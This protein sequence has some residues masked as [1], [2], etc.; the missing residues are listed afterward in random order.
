[1]STRKQRREIDK[2]IDHL[3]TYLGKK[4][5]WAKRFDEFLSQIM[6]PVADMSDMDVDDV[7]QYLLDGPYGNMAWGYLF[8]ELATS[9][10]DDEHHSMVDEYLKQRG[11]R[12]GPAGR[13]YLKALNSSDVKLWEVCNIKVGAHVDVRKFGS[14]DK[15]VRVK[16]VSASE[17]LQQW[18]CLAARVLN[19]DNSHMF[20][21]G[22]LLF[23]P[24][25]AASVQQVLDQVASE[26]SEFI[27]ESVD[28]GDI[29]ELPNDIDQQ[30]AEE[31]Q[32]QLTE[33]AFQIWAAA[34]IHHDNKPLPQLLNMDDE[35]IQ[36][37]IQRFPIQGDRNSIVHALDN[38]PLLNGD[39]EDGW[40][41]F[42]KP[43]AEIAD[44]ERISIH[45]RIEVKKSSIELET[46][47]TER[48]K[49]GRE[50][51]AALLGAHVG[52][53]LTVHEN[54]QDHP[55]TSV[56]QDSDV[57]LNALPEVQAA[58]QS[59]V[60]QHYRQTLDEPVPMLNNH[61]P[62]ECAKN[63]EL[64]PEVIKWLKSLENTH[65]RSPQQDYD[66]SWMWKEL[67]LDP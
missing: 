8:E 63:P 22:M 45:G 49:R 57:D 60:T 14:Q 64:Q 33:V 21:G 28:A 58:L 66:F 5:K 50:F 47:S 34:V 35:P 46:N 17:A 25:E 6:A 44:D 7:E 26:F 40:S 1:M 59:Y 29:D 37:T 67:D 2:A 23:A 39:E 15:P 36:L 4:D 51:L 24:E 42:P 65:Q 38:A 18:D 27:Q 56:D 54:W 3:M 10:W 31:V 16:E 43:Y 55:D 20:A 41:W 13:R 30:V 48:A 61:T 19:M 12:E 32:C 62:R 11:W 53:P 52:A 9:V